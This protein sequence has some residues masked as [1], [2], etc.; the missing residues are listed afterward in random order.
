TTFSVELTGVPA[1][2]TAVFSPTLTE[3]PAYQVAWAI[4]D[5]IELV[6]GTTTAGTEIALFHRANETNAASVG[7]A[8]LVAVF[9]WLEQTIGPYRF[10]PKAGGVSITWPIGGFGGM[11]HHPLW[12]V[13]RGSFA[14][15]ETQAH[16]AAH[17]WYG[18][19][20]R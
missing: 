18:D 20:I 8:N 2:K 17:G 10:G 1:G 3:A 12:H 11:E 13:S 6:L 4:D 19:G 7:G 16:E 14:S 9:D 5:Y 15:E